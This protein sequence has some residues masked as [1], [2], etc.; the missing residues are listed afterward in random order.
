LHPTKAKMYRVADKNI[1]IRPITRMKGDYLNRRKLKKK[2]VCFTRFE[3]RNNKGIYIILYY[4]ICVE[5]ETE[6]NIAFAEIT[7]SRFTQWRHSSCWN[8]VR[9]YGTETIKQTTWSCH[10]MSCHVVH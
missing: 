1:S 5:R 3:Q 6:R 9:S 8:A 10:V 7:S 4:I 2:K